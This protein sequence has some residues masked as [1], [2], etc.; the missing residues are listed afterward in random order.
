V[1]NTGTLRVGEVVAQGDVSLAAQQ[2]LSGG[3]A[4][5][6]IV[7]GNAIRSEATQGI[8]A[9]VA[10]R[11]STTSQSLLLQSEGSAFI[12]HRGALSLSG[13]ANGVMD[14]VAGDTITV[15]DTL[16]GGQSLTLSA[17]REASGGT[18][19]LV[20]DIVINGV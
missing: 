2:I 1:R 19:A 6:G 14:V 3:T 5:G 8:G 9:G 13:T 10:D 20:G 17:G 11:L 4:N 7:S 18:P 12:D 16:R 15:V